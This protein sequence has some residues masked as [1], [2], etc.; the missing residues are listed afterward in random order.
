MHPRHP[1]R[2][3]AH[4]DGRRGRTV[5][6]GVV[7]G[8][9]IDDGEGGK[10]V[11]N[12]RRH[13]RRRRFG[14]GRRRDG[15]LRRADGVRRLRSVFG[16]RQR[17]EL[18]FGRCGGG[19][20]GGSPA[21][22]LPGRPFRPRAFRVAAL[23]SPRAVR[24]LLVAN[25]TP[26]RAAAPRGI[27]VVG[28]AQRRPRGPLRRLIPQPRRLRHRHR[29][30]SVGGIV[31]SVDAPLSSPYRA[32]PLSFRGRGGRGHLPTRLHLRCEIVHR[33]GRG[34][35]HA[36]GIRD[37]RVVRHEGE[38]GDVVGV[39][40]VPPRVV[41][42]VSRKRRPRIVVVPQ[43]EGYGPLV[44]G[45]GG[46]HRRGSLH[47]VEL[48][49]LARLLGRRR[50]RRRRGG[51]G[52]R[53]RRSRRPAVVIVGGIRRPG[54]EHRLPSRLLLIPHRRRHHGR[55]GLSVAVLWLFTLR[56]L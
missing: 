28:Y 19:G 5:S 32:L 9:S 40:R 7:V 36:V 39:G 24:R 54:G 10:E 17:I 16:R 31:R 18:D 55:R 52:H 1:R 33:Y 27:H 48:L 20:G 41:V 3:V 45:D 30:A 46:G 6:R 34:R 14:G 8:G 21:V 25:R 37:V 56:L 15:V 51:G 53:H 42:R 29:T 23:V 2:D 50:R 43:G 22:V 26:R 47:V 11:G 13:G 49:P 44:R 4:D 12:V 38:G 35:R